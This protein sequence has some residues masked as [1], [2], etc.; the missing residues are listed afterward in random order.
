MGG[1]CT[2]RRP[3]THRAWS[4]Q[5]ATA[6]STEA[7][8][9]TVTVTD[10]ATPNVVASVSV[11]VVAAPANHFAMATT[12][13]PSATAGSS[14]SFTVTARDQFGNTDLTYGGTVHF[15][16]TDHSPGVVL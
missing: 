2:S 7:G 16:T 3:I 8:A 12:A 1:R 9:R 6:S 11:A 14:F 10:A 13:A 15:Q 4:Y 5:I